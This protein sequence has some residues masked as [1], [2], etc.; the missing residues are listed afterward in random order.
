MQPKQEAPACSNDSACALEAMRRNL[1]CNLCLTT[2]HFLSQAVN[3]PLSIT[4]RRD[5]PAEDS[6]NNAKNHCWRP[7]FSW[8]RDIHSSRIQGRPTVGPAAA[9]QQ[10]LS[11][12]L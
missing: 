7:K 3:I 4:Q 10:L 1:G 2:V 12:K 5:G 11:S 6:E 9:Q 8:S